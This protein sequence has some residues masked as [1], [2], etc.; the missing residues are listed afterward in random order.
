VCPSASICPSSG[1]PCA[2]LILTSLD[3]QAV[4]DQCYRNGG[5]DEDIDY[6]V[7]PDPPLNVEDAHWAD[8][9]LREAGR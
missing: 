3:L 1:F 5:Y 8:T 7:A 4:I 2:R 9:L 6:S